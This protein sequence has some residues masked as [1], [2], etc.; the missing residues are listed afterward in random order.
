MTDLGLKCGACAKRYNLKVVSAKI[1]RLPC[2]NCGEFISL[3]DDAD[4]RRGLMRTIRATIVPG[5]GARRPDLPEIV[6]SVLPGAVVLK[7]SRRRKPQPHHPEASK[8]LMTPGAYGVSDDDDAPPSAVREFRASKAETRPVT[9]I[10]PNPK[11][12]PAHAK[13]R[14]ASTPTAP[15]APPALDQLETERMVLPTDRADVLAESESD[16]DE[17]DYDTLGTLEDAA[18]QLNALGYVIVSVIAVLALATFAGLAYLLSTF[19]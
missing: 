4:A 12:R 18:V 11:T 15:A 5:P 17:A 8:P 16:A 14:L 9:P 13:L 3:P 6:S 1:T 10:A 19:V 7:K 2:P